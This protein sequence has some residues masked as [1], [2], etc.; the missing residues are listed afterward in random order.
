MSLNRVSPLRI[1]IPVFAVIA[2]I[3]VGFSVRSV[4]RYNEPVPVEQLTLDREELSFLTFNDT[5]R[6]TVSVIPDTISPE[7]L[8]WSSS[9]DGIASVSSDGVVTPVGNGKAIITVRGGYGAAVAHCTVSVSVVSSLS[10]ESSNLVLVPGQSARLN[11]QREPASLPLSEFRWSSSAPE[12]VSVDGSGFVTAH[13]GGTAQIYVSSPDGKHTDV[14]TVFVDDSVPLMGLELNVKEF[15]F[16]DDDD[17]LTLIPIFTPEDTTQRDLIWASSDETVATVDPETGVV[18]CHSNGTAIIQVRSAQSDFS[19]EC[20]VTVDLHVPLKGI[21]FTT[22]SY[23]FTALKQ[24]YII[25]PVFDPVDASIKDLTWKS[26]DTA[27]ATVSSQGAV[28]AVKRGTATITATSKEGNFKATFKVTVAPSDYVPV[29][30]VTL[31]SY[32]FTTE[33]IGDT[34]Q[35]SAS[36]KPSNASEKDLTYVSKNKKVATV[37]SKGVVT[38][39]GYGTAQIVVTATDGG[40]SEN[41]I[42]TA[43]EPVPVE[44][45]K[46]VT[47]VKAEYVEGVWV[48]TVGNLDFPSANNLTATQLKKEIDTLMDNIVSFGLNTVYFQV[49]P[50]GD[51]LYPS[52]YYPSS[53]FVVPKQGDALPM[54]ILD[55]AIK[56]AHSRGLSFHAWINPYRVTSST[57]STAPLA[58]TNPAV[59]HPEW[60][61]TDGTKLYLNPGLPE[62][63]QYIIDGVLEIV[64]KYDV[65]GIHFDDYFYPDDLTKWKD[66]DAYKKYGNGLSLEDWRR[67]NNNALVKDC[68]DAIKKADPTVQF[69]ISPAAVW[70]TSANMAGGV[71]IIGG[72]LTFTQAFA[73]TK[74]WVEE[75]W[76]DYI[77]PQIYFQI[78]H[79]TAPFKPIA[80]W[81]NALCAKGNV[82]LYIGI[83]AYRCEDTSAYKGGKEIPAQLDY[84][85]NLTSVDGVVFFRY[86]SLVKNHADVGDQIKDR[87]YIKP[88][89]TELKLDRT[90]ETLDSSYKSTYIIGISDP[91][92]P[93]YADGVPVER[94]TDGYFAHYVSLT[95]SKTVVTFT[96]KGKTVEYVINRTSSSNTGSST[97]MSS[98]GFVS[99]SFT[100]AF[101]FADKSGATLTLSCVAPAGSKVTVKI[102][103]Y[104]VTLKTTTKAPSNGTYK[105]AT[106]TGTFTL[107]QVDGGGNTNLGYVVFY[108]EKGKETAM[109]SPGCMVEVINDSDSYVMQ[110]V[111]DKSFIRPNLEVC[112]EFYHFATKGSKINVLSKADGTVKL[113]NGMYM[114]TTDLEAISGKLSKS[115]WKSMKMKNTDKYT[116]FSLGLTE[117]V[118]HDLWMNETDVEI[119][120]YDVTGDLPS[121]TL[122][123]NPLFSA[124]KIERMNET[125]IRMVLTYKEARH[126]YGYTCAFDGT[127]LNISFRNPSKLASGD[128]PLKGIVISIDPGH[129]QNSGAVGTYNK[130]EVYESTLNLTL[131]KLAAE[132][133]RAMGATVVLSHQGEGTY[134]LEELILQFRDLKPDVNVS[135]HFNS[136]SGN[137][138]SLSGTF[139]YWCYRNSQLLSDVM[140]EEFTKETGLKKNRSDCNC[141]QVSRFCDFP[142]ILFETAYICNPT[143][144]AWFMKEE[145]MDRAADAI[146]K[147]LLAYFR[148]QND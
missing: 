26:S 77:C 80:D 27:I 140:L 73:D 69:G 131:S 53:A 2:L 134:S 61:V 57:T 104:V 51:A 101:D 4:L 115:A 63:R 102:G 99:G 34:V 17:A 123:E 29:T 8:T 119:Y 48:A 145:N 7:E 116:V 19:A 92:F 95:Q 49:R 1:L 41:F 31:K 46:P 96:H 56:A 89:S 135:I 133:L 107:P 132:K 125:T 40:Y 55:Y 59:R 78:S 141:Y 43:T 117:T 105:K 62:V 13:L 130:K 74:K 38:V 106:Y 94:T 14:C 127:T 9:D 42:V 70:N 128:Q 22:D 45:Q 50:N 114:A 121:F 76:L 23:T 90:S 65:D 91:N 30:G 72:Y 5:Y 110:V 67:E 136:H 87:F 118:F 6:L 124:I 24:V 52:E 25:T 12:I 144:V 66:G 84:L 93:L 21:S 100:P 112:R 16:D 103:T 142:S 111:N 28:T 98:F 37:N 10:F 81:W 122:G 85:E 109:Y 79:S 108:A 86:D 146:A 88:I 113:S 75:G 3:A 148:A 44:P 97:T 32:T 36:V 15:V 137:P 143:D 58:K 82:D 68:Y 33:K 18:T 54:D 139:T 60:V 126:I 83:G 11:L 138:L 71:D 129:S 35:I 147:G 120:L 64:K 20:K 39:V 47:S